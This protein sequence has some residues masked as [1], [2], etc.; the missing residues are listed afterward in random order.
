MKSLRIVLV[1]LEA[2]VPFGHVTGRW[3]S[4]LLAEL[5]RRG[6][7]VTAFAACSQ[8]AEI[9]AA[10]MLFP[11]PQYDL[12]LY[13]FPVRRGL[14]AKLDSF[15]KPFSYPFSD[16]LKADL[17]S[18]LA[19]GYDVLHLE[20]LAS[21]WVAPR[22]T[23]RC[24]LN[25]LFLY[26][27]DLEAIAPVG[28]RGRLERYLMRKAERRLLNRFR[29][30][31]TLSDRLAYRVR[32]IAPRTN[33][34]VA[35]FGIDPN[36]YEYIADECRTTT[37]IVSVIGNM[38]WYPSH[39][40][41]VRLLTRLWP[42]IKARVPTARVQIVGWG[43]RTA[44]NEYLQLPDVEILENVPDIRPYFQRTG[45][46]LYAPGRG[47]GMK[48]KILEAF[49]FGIPVVT[50]SEGVE[51][52][53]ALDGIHA[54]IAETD[55][56]LIARTVEL[57]GDS[58]RQNRYRSAARRLLEDHCGP[59][60]SVDAIERIYGQMRESAGESPGRRFSR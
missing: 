23:N 50:T 11:A 45:V 35:P 37:P 1:F 53:P 7:R 32:Q 26:A 27:I 38:N 58:D 18:T 6:H 46:L 36:L 42:G 43:A 55:A 47:S 12:R 9:D 56:D 31:R 33:V 54:G 39:S 44:L 19:D 21:G 41:A 40:A 51:G 15:R 5:V 13:P 4:V 20:E 22:E 59:G 24:L 17:N 8:R 34:M 25:V 52:I 30:I 60:P 48:V 14:R 28:W 10:R 2:P 3:S 16:E 49:A 57:L 29:L